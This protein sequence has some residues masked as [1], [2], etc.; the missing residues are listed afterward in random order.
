MTDDRPLDA[1][2]WEWSG[3]QGIDAIFDSVGAPTLPRSVRA[4]ARGGRVV[5]IGATAGPKVEVDVRPLFWRQTSIRGSTMASRSEFEKVYELIRSRQLVPVVDHEFRWA[6]RRKAWDR[7]QE[8]DLFG[9][10][11]LDLTDLP[12]P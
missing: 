3:K 1:V 7:F 2:L 6:D 4:L 12:G 10:V 11:V 5:V 8:P 9:K